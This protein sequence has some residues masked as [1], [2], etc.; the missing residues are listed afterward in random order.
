MQ[1]GVTNKEYLSAA[2]PDPSDAQLTDA[3]SPVFGI[4]LVVPDYRKVDA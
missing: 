3:T 1:C 2:Q 4:R